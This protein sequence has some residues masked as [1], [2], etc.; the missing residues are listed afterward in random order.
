MATAKPRLIVR[1]RPIR[2]VHEGGHRFAAHI[3]DHEVVIDQP[4]A[5]GG[6]DA[7]PA[8]IELLTTSLVACVAHYGH[9]F[10]RRNGLPD[11]VEAEATWWADLG[12]ERLDRVEI[13]V[14]APQVPPELEDGFRDALESCLVH[15]S[16][17]Q[18]PEIEFDVRV[19]V[20]GLVTASSGA[21]SSPTS[22]VA[23]G[24]VHER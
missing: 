12:G 9:M 3:R 6:G 15:N 21:G 20:D 18:P 14:F 19:D 22:R 11:G 2:V 13:R 24:L 1:G 10:C 23:A 7:G 8:P 17:L 5:S 4:E 16:L